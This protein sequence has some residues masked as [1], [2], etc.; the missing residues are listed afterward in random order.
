MIVGRLCHARP[1]DQG[2]GVG[3]RLVEIAEEEVEHGEIVDL[4]GGCSDSIL[5]VIRRRS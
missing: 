1:I 2:G 3:S 4:N 5:V